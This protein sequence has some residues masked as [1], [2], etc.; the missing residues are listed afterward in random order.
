MGLMVICCG[1]AVKGCKECCISSVVDG[2]D[3]D[4]LWNGSRDDDSDIEW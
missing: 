2:T 1:M 4:M 3:G